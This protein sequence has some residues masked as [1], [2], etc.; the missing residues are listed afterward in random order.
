MLT[1]FT[2]CLEKCKTLS[3]D[4]T[5]CDIFWALGNLATTE[6]DQINVCKLILES[7]IWKNDVMNIDIRC[8]SK[9]LR[10]EMVNFIVKTLLPFTIDIQAYHYEVEA[11]LRDNLIP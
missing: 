11:S 6:G 3:D 1:S 10:F 9:N 5:Q 7:H 4:V 2:K 8:K